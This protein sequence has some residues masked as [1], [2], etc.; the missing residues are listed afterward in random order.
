LIHGPPHISTFRDRE[1]G[2]REGLAARGLELRP[3]WRQAG[4]SHAAGH[5][6]MRR[7]MQLSEP[8]TAVFAANDVT[9]FGAIDGALSLGR[10]VPDDVWVIGYDDIDL[11]SHTNPPLTSV[12][13]DKQLMGMQGLWH[14]SERLHR[15]GIAHR[16]T[17]LPVQ[18]VERES[19][20]ATT[21]R[22]TALA[23]S[24]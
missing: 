13:V 2:F 14:L 24:S 8:P 20:S 16:E 5:H 22:A 12:T 11:A 10:R 21:R 1:Q 4:I 17:R 19:S 3:E 6:A 7:I 15:P 23:I 9:A 18:I